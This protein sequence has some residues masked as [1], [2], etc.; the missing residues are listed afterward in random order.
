M[1]KLPDDVA[2][3]DL[4]IAGVICLALLTTFRL[5]SDTVH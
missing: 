2:N 5:S 3:A 1:P 4:S